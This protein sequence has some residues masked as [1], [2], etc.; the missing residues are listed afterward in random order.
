M[1]RENQT[2]KVI[3]LMDKKINYHLY[4]SKISIYDDVELTGTKS[5]I[6]KEAKAYYNKYNI[7]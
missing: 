7:E 1:L 3:K 4:I 6:K 5:V 2:E